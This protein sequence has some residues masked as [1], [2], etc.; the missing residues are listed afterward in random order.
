M[1]TRRQFLQSTLATLIA[2][3]LPIVSTGAVIGNVGFGCCNP[4]QILHGSNKRIYSNDIWAKE[5]NKWKDVS[6]EA[7]SLG[8]TNNDYP[9]PD[10]CT[11][12]SCPIIDTT[13]MANKVWRTFAIAHTD[14]CNRKLKA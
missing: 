11:A 14:E 13:T 7:D 9:D 4:N 12:C 1:Q 2:P 5:L 8:P 3:A 6:L 10:T